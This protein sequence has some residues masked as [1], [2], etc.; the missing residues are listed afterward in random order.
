ME[1]EL[2][3]SQID[4]R[5]VIEAGAR[6]ERTTVRGPAMIG[7]GRRLRDCYIGPYTAIGEGCA[8]HRRRRSSTRSCSPG[9]P[10][11]ISTGAWSPRCSGAT[12]PCAAAS[13]SRG[14]TASWSGDNSDISIL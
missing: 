14:R 8:D 1:G 10:C 7:A 2:I 4:G 11:A 5:V 3:D 9:R 12:S 6:L 13:A